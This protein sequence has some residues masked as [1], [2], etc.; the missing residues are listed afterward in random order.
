MIL[1]PAIETTATTRRY[2]DGQDQRLSYLDTLQP[3]PA[4]GN[5]IG[6]WLPIPPHGAY[7]VGEVRF[8]PAAEEMEQARRR[9]R[10]AERLVSTPW[11]PSVV[12]VWAA[13]GDEARLLTKGKTS[14]YG[15][16]NAVLSANT[17]AEAMLARVAVSAE[18]RCRAMLHATVRGSGDVEAVLAAVRGQR[19][20]DREIGRQGDKETGSAH[21]WD[22][23]VADVV[24]G[25]LR[26]LLGKALRLE[27]DAT[28]AARTEL[29]TLALT[30]WAHRLMSNDNETLAQPAAP[31]EHFNL[32]RA[33]LHIDWPQGSVV[34]L[35]TVRKLVTNGALTV[36]EVGA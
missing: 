14:G 5:E 30:E 28:G 10:N 32:H 22:A 15:A 4:Q 13:R 16:A 26:R 31:L 2:A 19:S 24:V 33:D 27:I 35:R 34:T 9:A 11:E 36:A 12:Y 20:E 3:A 17:G 6:R 21:S 23:T 1:L 7:L 8:G 29:E 18:L 25:R